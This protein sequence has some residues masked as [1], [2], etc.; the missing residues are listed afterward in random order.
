MDQPLKEKYL[1][2]GQLGLRKPR[3]LVAPLDWGLGHATRCIPLIKCLLEQG[4]EVFLAGEGAQETLLKM[5]FPQLPF[6]QLTGYRIS[7]ARTA[8]GLAWK[9]ILQGPKMRRAIQ[10]EHAWLKKKVE[11]HAFDAVISDN[12]YGL[13]HKNIPCIFMTHQLCI[14]SSIGK[15][16]ERMLQKKNYNYIRRFTECW[17][18]D[19]Q[20]ELNLA[21]G[22]SHPEKKPGIPMH[23]TGPLS[24]FQKRPAD[25]KHGRLVVILSGPEPQRSIL[26]EIIIRQISHYDGTATIVRGLP[27]NASV[28]PSTNM[29]RFYNHLG[30]TE[31]NKEILEAEFVIG[32]CGYSTVMDL[33]RLQK[34]SVLIPTPGQTEQEYLARQLLKNQMAFSVSQKEFVLTDVLQTAR[35]F[36]YRF[37]SLEGESLGFVVSALFSSLRNGS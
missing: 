2:G 30:T 3:I 25:E 33:A 8:R 17:I 14:Q 18:P 1:P 6:I 32:R 16:V 9:M 34:K 35:A 22:L 11:E 21:G 37:P 12:R 20:G 7:Y 29:I 5:E 31:L 28:L 23:Y 36:S 15:W 27:G 10:Y 24:R 4:A 26:E 13:Y 19:L